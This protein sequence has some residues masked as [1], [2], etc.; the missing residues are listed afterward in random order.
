MASLS[1][2]APAKLNLFLHITGRR[3]DG[4]HNLQT[5]FQLLDYG[6]S[7]EFT[8]SESPCIQL[9][10]T[11]EG[12]Q[13]QDN[14]IYRAAKLLQQKAQ[15]HCG[16]TIY[17]NKQLPM[18]G[19][20]GGGSSNAATTL[21]GLNHLWQT[22]LSIDELCQLGRQL[23]ADVPVFVGGKTAWAQGVG[24]QLKPVELEPS[25]YLVLTPPCSVSTAAI[26]SHPDLVRDTPAISLDYFLSQGGS[27]N[28]QPLVEQL[29][30]PVKQA[31]DWLSQFGKATMT[32]TGA[33]VFASFPSKSAAEKVLAQ[34]PKSLTG[35]IAKGVNTSPLHKKLAEYCQVMV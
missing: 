23:G 34:K 3:P 9:S 28:C 1:L 29:H 24:E 13:D 32:G 2:P 19:G 35:F 18:G 7:L 21:I 31:I 30:P 5:L 33:S 22:G 20:I 25:W 6:D 27:N 17:L 14:L 4:Y 15:L 26:F 16:A 8:R 11:L 10:P 12:V